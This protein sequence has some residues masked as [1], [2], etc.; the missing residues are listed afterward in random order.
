M[1]TAIGQNTCRHRQL[2]KV[3]LQST[4]VKGKCINLWATHYSTPEQAAV[5]MQ[6]FYHGVGMI[7]SGFTVPSIMDQHQPHLDKEPGVM[8][9]VQQHMHGKAR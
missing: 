8:C 1:V 7:P 2:L 5:A 3:V 4:A 6:P 9:Q